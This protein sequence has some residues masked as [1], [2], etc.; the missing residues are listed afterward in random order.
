MGN[1]C[2]QLA[3]CTMCVNQRWAEKHWIGNI[4]WV[5]CF[6]IDSTRVCLFLPFS[7]LE[8]KEFLIFNFRLFP[9][10]LE[11]WLNPSKSSTIPWQAG[12]NISPASLTKVR[13]YIFY[14]SWRPARIGGCGWHQ[15]TWC[16]EPGCTTSQRF[17]QLN[18]APLMPCNNVTR[19]VIIQSATKKRENKK[20]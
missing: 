9:L 4:L 8:K 17:T 2:L 7:K 10:L 15:L 11:I 19:S 20:K 14:F 12:T 1:Q 6:L 5:Q 3:Q 18:T 13:L 16:I